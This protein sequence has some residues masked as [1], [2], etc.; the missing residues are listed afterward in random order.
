MRT[1]IASMLLLICVSCIAGCLQHLTE[2]PGVTGDV[3]NISG[4]PIA[5]AEVGFYWVDSET[6]QPTS[7]G[8]TRPDACVMTA[9]DGYFKLPA[10][11]LWEWG[12][13]VYSHPRSSPTVS[14][15]LF[16][17]PHSTARL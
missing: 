6:T 5:G 17:P 16:M 14:A 11:Q 3:I 1:P 15:C 12:L 7:P 13:I 9:R 2:R 4:A 8:A 10:R